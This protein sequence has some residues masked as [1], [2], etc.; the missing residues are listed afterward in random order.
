[1]DRTF[2]THAALTFAVLSLELPSLLVLMVLWSGAGASLGTGGAG[3]DVRP[4]LELVC[5]IALV[6]VPLAVLLFAARRRYWV[7]AAIQLCV[8]L[9]EGLLAYVRR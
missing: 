4:G 3:A 5:R 8:L 1:M 2:T 6:M 9:T 7:P